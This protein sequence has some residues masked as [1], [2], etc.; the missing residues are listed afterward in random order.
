[1]EMFVTKG[2]DAVKQVTKKGD[3]AQ[4][5]EKGDA[6]R[7]R[8]PPACTI[9]ASMH[10]PAAAADNCSDDVQNS[11]EMGSN[12]RVAPRFGGLRPT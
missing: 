11:L 3:T 4:D 5:N 12:A 2:K 10:D 9:V 8:V 1:M 6:A 7:Y